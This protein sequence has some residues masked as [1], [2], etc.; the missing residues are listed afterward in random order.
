MRGAWLVALMAATSAA[1]Q[2]GFEGTYRPTIDAD[3]ARVGET[4]GALQIA[5]GVFHGL[6][7]EC[8]MTMPTPVRDMDAVL[9]DMSCSGGGTDWQERALFMNAADGGLIMVWNGFAFHY[10]RCEAGVPAGTV[11]RATDLGV[12][13]ALD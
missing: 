3:C 10:D 4:G 8:Q 5:D 12:S 1:A 9:Y 2:D 6:E 13:E 7:T 11:S